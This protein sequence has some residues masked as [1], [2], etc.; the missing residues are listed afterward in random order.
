MRIIG[1]AVVSCYIAGVAMVLMLVVSLFSEQLRNAGRTLNR[2]YFRLCIY[3]MIHC[4]L[5][6]AYNAMYGHPEPWCRTV[7]LV[8]R[9]LRECVNLL[10]VRR[11]I[12]YVYHRLYGE[13]RMRQHW[14]PRLYSLVSCAFVALIAVNLATGI[15]F[16][17]T[18]EN[19]I[20]PKPLLYIIEGTEYLCFCSAMLIVKRHHRTSSKIQFFHVTPMIVMITLS[21]LAQFVIRYDLT[22]LG[23]AACALMLY[24]SM[25]GEYRFVDDR[26]GLYNRGYLTYLTEAAMNGKAEIRG[27]LILEAGGN[28]P[29]AMKV[30]RSTLHRTGDVIRV[31]EDKCL[32][33]SREGDVSTMQYLASQVDDAVARYNLDQPASDKVHLDVR[34][35]VRKEGEDPVSFLHSVLEAREEASS[36]MKG[37]VSMMSEMDRLDQELK[38]AEDIQRSMIPQNFP[39]FPGRT[40]FDLYASMTPALEVGGDFYDFFLVDE[41][42][43]ALVIA[44]VSG[45]GIPAALFMMMSRTLIRNQLMTGID[46]AAALEQVNQQI[47]EHNSAMMF[48][49]VWCAVLEISTGK[50]VACNA[51][52]EKPL[53]RRVDGAFELLKYRHGISVGVFSGI[54][55]ENRV[56]ELRPGDS[57]FVYTDG[58]PE[59]TNGAEDMFGPDR[60]QAAL[61]QNADA[62]PEEL[63]RRVGE[64]ANRFVDGA[65]KFDDMTMLCLKYRGQR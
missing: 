59:A 61:N 10:I 49:T 30:L 7:A 9:S 54:K 44:D 43:L 21:G 56:F 1:G 8:S 46:P 26:S 33:F 16:T 3:V 65:P 11:W 53:L 17:L 15:V 40:E 45:K 58:V 27:A 4:V 64:E 50:G 13:R 42:H 41:D 37:I 23:E 2:D 32:T 38:L 14:E 60:L 19:N 63:V 31:S 52:H 22:C 55:Y 24:F 18:A 20:E 57:I 62:P 6:L 5:S 29:G 47:R 28:I 36:E 39:P 51:G 48:V 34:G 35:M 12:L 25:I